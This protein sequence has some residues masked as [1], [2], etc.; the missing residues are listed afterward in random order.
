MLVAGLAYLEAVE[1]VDRLSS[2][3]T[4]VVSGGLSWWED[5]VVSEWC[6]QRIGH[7]VARCEGT[8]G[9]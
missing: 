8:G 3:T 9:G 5:V 7:H 6:G 2:R 1:V 4:T